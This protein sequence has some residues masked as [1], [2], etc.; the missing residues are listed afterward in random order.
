MTRTIK[1]VAL[2]ATATV[3]VAVIWN[4]ILLIG[5]RGVFTR[6]TP[7]TPQGNAR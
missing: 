7:R 6:R 1:T 2:A 5:T 3:V 4:P